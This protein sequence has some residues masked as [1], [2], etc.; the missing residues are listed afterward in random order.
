MNNADSL[1][2]LNP[3]IQPNFFPRPLRSS[4]NFCFSLNGFVLLPVSF[5]LKQSLL[6]KIGSIEDEFIFSK[7]A[8]L[9]C[10]LHILLLN[11]VYI[12]EKGTNSFVC[13]YD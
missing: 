10:K 2:R 11:F 4:Q 1:P 12:F 7:F 8:V 5:L 9:S 13:D 6:K 3:L